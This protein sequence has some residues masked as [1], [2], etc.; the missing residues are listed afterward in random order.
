M[1]WKRRTARR[2]I[3]TVLALQLALPGLLL[4]CKNVLLFYPARR[5]TPAE[6]LHTLVGTDARLIVVTRP[7]GRVLTG[8]DVRPKGGPDAPVLLYFHGNAGNAATRASWLRD[9]VR[10]SALRIVLASYSGYGGNAGDPSEDDLYVDALAFYDHLIASGVPA[11]QIVVYGESI[12]GAPATYVATERDC[13]GLILQATF[14]SLPS[15]ARELYPWL[16]LAAILTRGDFPNGERAGAAACP[17]LIV[18]GT[19][20]GSVP[21]SE[22][23]K[24][25]AAAPRAEFM[26]ITGAGHNDLWYVGGADYVRRVTAQ[27][28]AWTAATADDPDRPR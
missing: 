16:P 27:V 26:A 15:M 13:A 10:K 12:G 24:I 17:L 7:D 14:S 2:V 5:P 18:H 8:Y 20:D 3:T 25:A 22:S 21:F 9:V 11:S 6:R 4:A 1:T 23:R 28:R 19:N